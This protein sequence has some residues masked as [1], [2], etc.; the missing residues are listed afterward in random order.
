MVC[1]KCGNE[2]AEGSRFCTVCGEQVNDGFQAGTEN[3]NANA[4]NNYGQY[5]N[6][7]SDNQNAG[8]YY[9][10]Q[11]SGAPYYGEQPYSCAPQVNDKAPSLKDY[12]KWILLYPLWNFI[13]GVGFIIYILVCFKHAFDTTNKAKSNFFKA[14]LVSQAITIGITVIMMII[15]F[16]I[17][18]EF[19]TSVPEVFEEIDPNFFFEYSE[20]IPYSDSFI[21]IFG[22]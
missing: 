6:N 8:G 13:P 14:M 7:A 15:F 11:Q 1:K 18:G 2:I 16:S 4:N 21:R 10:Q 9:Y 5:N 17:V 19:A 22:R 3:F 12:L 20:N